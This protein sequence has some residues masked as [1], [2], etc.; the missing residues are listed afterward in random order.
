MPQRGLAACPSKPT[1]MYNICLHPKSQ[2]THLPTAVR[3]YNP[4][5]G[6]N[7]VFWIRTCID[8]YRH[9]VSLQQS[10]RWWKCCRRL[11]HP[12]VLSLA[13]PRWRSGTGAK[14]RRHRNPMKSL[15]KEN[16]RNPK[17]KFQMHSNV[18]FSS[19]WHIPKFGSKRTCKFECRRQWFKWLQR[20]PQTCD[21]PESMQLHV[22][23]N[24]QVT[25]IDMTGM[26]KTQ[27]KKRISMWSPQRVVRVPMRL[28]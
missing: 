6:K 21:V 14:W 17:Y 24:G 7:H 18:M 13:L 27:A 12:S 9:T 20:F 15:R 28:H 8:M 16:I 25:I 3:I 1:Y 19:H 11:I 5:G 2:M 26:L 23:I 4:R 10:E 22:L